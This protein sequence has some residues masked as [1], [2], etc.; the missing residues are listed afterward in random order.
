MPQDV[1]DEVARFYE[2]EGARLVE[3][4]RQGLLAPISLELLKL[5]TRSLVNGLAHLM[6]SDDPQVPRLTPDKA[7]EVAEQVT[8][9]L[10]LGLLPRPTPR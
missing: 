9:V 5:S 10:G 8:R 3:A 4:Q 2:Q 1:R 6:I 7:G